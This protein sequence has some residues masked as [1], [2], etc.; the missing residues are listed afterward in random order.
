VYDGWS[1]FDQ[2]RSSDLPGFASSRA[3]TFVVDP[4]G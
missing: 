1:A 2:N 3:T 4:E